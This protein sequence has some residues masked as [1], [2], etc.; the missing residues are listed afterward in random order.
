VENHHFEECIGGRQE[1]AHDDLEELLALE[2]LLVRGKLDFKL[3]EKGVDGILLE[4]H[5]AVEDAENR[6]QTELVESTL[7]RL[8]LVGADLGPLLGVGVEV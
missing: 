1:L 3:S 6:V 2:V 7:K 5:D 4:V 8:A